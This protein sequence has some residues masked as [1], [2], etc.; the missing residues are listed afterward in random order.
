MPKVIRFIQATGENFA[1]LR[2]VL[3]DYGKVTAL[4]GRNGQG[5]TSIGTIPI[6]TLWGKDL[7]GADYMKPAFSPRPSNYKYDRVFASIILSVDGVEYKFTRE[8]KG[9]ANNF[10]INDVPKTATEYADAVAALID[11]DEF[12]AL[13]FP[14]YFFGLHWTKQRELLMRGVAAPTNKTVF[15]E[16][17]RTSPEQKVKDILLNP[18][19]VKLAELVKKH[20][21]DDLQAMHK[22]QKPELEKQ[23]IA[24][25]SRTKTL[26][27]QLD[28][29][30]DVQESFEVL[31]EQVQIARAVFEK[32][33]AIVAEA[34]SINSHYTA[35]KA[36]YDS[37]QQ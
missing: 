19:A 29:L 4:S 36:R 33:D 14:A 6:W 2:S 24:A 7:F 20:S 27:E 26:Q 31:E 12:M 28:R 8:I 13:Y 3:V 23:H 17:S 22:K 11:Q 37:L 32:E 35:L 5:K 16:M 1:G 9:K 34:A 25:E 30:P 21:L 18:Q 15:A 10:Y